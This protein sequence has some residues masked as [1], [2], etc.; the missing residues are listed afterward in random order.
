MSKRPLI[1]LT[2]D[3]GIASEALAA[4]ASVLSRDAD[5][6]V[7]APATEQSATSHRIT[8]TG[9]I[10]VRK[11][12]EGW[13]AVHG[14]P[15]DC[16][17]LAA[18]V[19]DGGIVPD[20]VVSGPNRG[21][22]LGTDVFYSGTVAAAMEGALRGFPAISLSAPRRSTRE[23]WTLAAEL[24]LEIWKSLNW[25]ELGPVTVNVNLPEEPARGLRWT[26]MG[27]RHYPLE[28]TACSDPFGRT[29][30]W[31]G[32][33]GL[34]T[35]EGAEGEDAEAVREGFAS[36]SL[37]GVDLTIVATS[38]PAPERIMPPKGRRIDHG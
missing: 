32:G 25:A 13:Y 31:I 3:D 20:L 1:L 9:P 38:L 29:Y 18:A 16:V 26:A 2:N 28:A 8:L 7:V 5:L 10:Q 4:A 12:D 35:Y 33:Q 11:L 19:L 37:I 14:S 24:A 6:V 17:Y 22:N 30:Y 34:G 27:R 36:A 21:L 23:H 15:A